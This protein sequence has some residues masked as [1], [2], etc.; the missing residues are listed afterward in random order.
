MIVVESMFFDS[1]DYQVE[2][3]VI[4]CESKEIA[5]QVVKKTYEKLLEGY[6]FDEEDE[7]ENRKSFERRYVKKHKNGSIDI[8]GSDCGYGWI[9]IIE[10]EPI[11]ANTISSFDPVVGNIY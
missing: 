5:K 1:D 7:D 4:P 3:E 8:E 9:K 10:K 11:T 2:S 6:D